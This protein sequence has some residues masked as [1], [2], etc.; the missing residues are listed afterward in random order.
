MKNM[1]LLVFF[2]PTCN[3]SYNQAENDCNCHV[4]QRISHRCIHMHQQTIRYKTNEPDQQIGPLKFFFCCIRLFQDEIICNL[5]S[6]HRRKY[7]ANQIQKVCNIV[8]WIKHRCNRSN[9]RYNHSCPLFLYFRRN[10][11]G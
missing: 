10:R 11:Y 9:D 5:N 8:H 7:R 1:C 4:W 3:F 6:N 2:S